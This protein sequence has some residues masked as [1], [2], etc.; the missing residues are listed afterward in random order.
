MTDNGRKWL[1]TI[2]ILASVGLN[3]LNTPE[4]QKY[5]YPLN[6]YVSLLGSLTLLWVSKKQKDTP[7]MVLNL[8]VMTIYLAAIYNSFQYM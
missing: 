8:T 7:Y 6:L 4:F 3:S 1:G 2:L 5:V